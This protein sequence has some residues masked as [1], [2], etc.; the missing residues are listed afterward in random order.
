ML[1]RDIRA[2]PVMGGERRLR[3]ARSAGADF[4]E[5]LAMLAKCDANELDIA[6][7]VLARRE[8]RG[9]EGGVLCD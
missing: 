7:A 5:V 8:G 2:I 9:G 4:H 1:L 6:A 3:L